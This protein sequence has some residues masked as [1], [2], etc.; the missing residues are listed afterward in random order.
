MG[1]FAT[2]GARRDREVMAQLSAGSELA[3]GVLE[4][5]AVIGVPGTM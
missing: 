3:A 2:V 4:M 5:R 1:R